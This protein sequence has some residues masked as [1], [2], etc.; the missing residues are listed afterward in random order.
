MAIT[1]VQWYE[2]HQEVIYLG[3]EPRVSASLT[4]TTQCSD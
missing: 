1:H 4:W 3:F 2:A